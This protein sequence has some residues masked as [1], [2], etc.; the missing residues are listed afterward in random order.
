MNASYLFA[1]MPYTDVL[2]GVPDYFNTVI[3]LLASIMH[4]TFSAWIPDPSLRFYDGIG[5]D[6]LVGV[7]FLFNF[8][9]VVYMASTPVVLHLK[10]WSLD[11]S[12][13]YK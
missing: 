13:N 2:N 12:R 5:F 3:L 7:C 1:T 4:V 6:L 9:Y 10:R 11:A 8:G